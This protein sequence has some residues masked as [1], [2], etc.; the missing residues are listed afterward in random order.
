MAAH[1][2]RETAAVASVQ[3]HTRIVA[4]VAVVES[5]ATTGARSPF[6]FVSSTVGGRV[7]RPAGNVT[8]SW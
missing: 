7:N 8:T 2:V 1:M 5:I 4:E 6:V 3:F